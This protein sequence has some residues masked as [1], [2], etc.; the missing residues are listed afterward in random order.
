MIGFLACM[1]A[2]PVSVRN[3]FENQ[4]YL[5]PDSEHFYR[6]V[7]KIEPY[8][9]VNETSWNLYYFSDYFMMIFWDIGAIGAV[10]IVI[11][12]YIIK[13]GDKL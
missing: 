6:I 4:I 12:D 1:I 11:S 8:Y 10:F 13:K 9:Y 7:G 3:I 5:N 2:T